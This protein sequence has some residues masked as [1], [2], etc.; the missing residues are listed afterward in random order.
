MK[1][2]GGS[3][4]SKQCC[5]KRK[6][7]NAVVKSERD[8]DEGMMSDPESEVKEGESK[9]CLTFALTVFVK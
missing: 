5:V 7:P 9:V 4:K 6:C 2:F 3:G 8:E 1:R